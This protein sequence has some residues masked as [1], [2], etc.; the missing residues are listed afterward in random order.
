[1]QR[2]VIVGAVGIV[3]TALLATLLFGSRG[4]VHLRA[5][6]REQSVLDDRITAM[7]R[8]NEQLRARLQKL[9]QD[10]RYLERLAREQLG[11]VRR[12]EVVYR[13]PDRRHPDRP[14]SR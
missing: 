3:A 2:Q 6:R 12:G 8:E 7:L 9:R 10:D 5:L 1:M 4:L 11:F 14:D 13:F